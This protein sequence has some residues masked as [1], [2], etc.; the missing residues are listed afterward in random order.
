MTRTPQ[1]LERIY[2]PPGR[3]EFVHDLGCVICGAPAEN[4]HTRTGGTSRKGHYTTIIPLCTRHHDESHHGIRTFAAKYRL[5][6]EVIAAA[7]ESAWL[8]HSAP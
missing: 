4:A 6:L 2:G 7:V 8:A 3:R 1:D 5:D